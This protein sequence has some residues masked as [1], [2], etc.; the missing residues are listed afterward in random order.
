M[1]ENKKTN[2][3]STIRKAEVSNGFQTG[4]QKIVTSLI[5]SIATQLNKYSLTLS[6]YQ[7]T[8][9]TAAINVMNDM[10]LKEG[11]EFSSFNQS[12][13]SS[14]LFKIAMF[15][16]NMNAIPRECYL[17]FRN[18]KNTKGEWVKEFEFGL[19]G[20]GNDK[21]LRKYG[22]N[23]KA[24]HQPWLIR[25]GDEFTFPQYKG[26]GMSEPCWTPKSSSGKIIRVLYPIEMKDGTA[27]YLISERE[28]V[29]KNLQAHIS[30][31]LLGSKNDG[32]RAK[33]LDKIANMSLDAMLNDKELENYISPA[34]RNP[35]SRDAMILRKMRNNATKNY[36]KDFSDSFIADAYQ[37][38]YE[39]YDQY[40]KNDSSRNIEAEVVNEID[41]SG[42]KTLQI[43]K[44]AEKTNIVSVKS[45]KPIEHIEKERNEKTSKEDMT[46][47]IDDLNLGW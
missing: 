20:D 45:S 31:N 33:I 28:D 43:E 29:A 13:I 39:D 6:D 11:R 42:E 36:P 41:N 25:E 46:K 16:L 8:C 35:Q 18:T 26:L 19:E 12:I 9:L 34:W 1:E 24:V 32:V 37:E 2:E 27:E 23:I 47:Q 10:A 5:G 44:P 15:N 22:V 21:I 38:T 17:Q 3:V 4:Q 7:K 30:N 40:R 14:I